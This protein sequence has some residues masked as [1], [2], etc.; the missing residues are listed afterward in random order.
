MILEAQE[1]NLHLT[2]VTVKTAM[3]KLMHQSGYSFVFEASDLI[4]RKKVSVSAD[5]LDS[6]I[7]Q[8]LQGQDVC[9][10]IISKSIVISSCHGPGEK[11]GNKV[12]VDGTVVDMASNPIPGATIIEKGTTN[13]TVCGPDG[14]FAISINEGTDLICSCLG[15]KSII[16]STSHNTA[17][18]VTLCED[19]RHIDESIIVGYGTV[20]RKNVTGSISSVKKEDLNTVSS[21]SVNLMLQGRVSG[22]SSIQQSAQ[23]GAGA[24]IVIRGAASPNGSNSPLYVIDGVP[25]QTFISADPG[26]EIVGYELMT[27]IDRD[28]LNTLNPNDI[29]RIEVLK[30]ASAAIYGASAAN[31][32]I[33]ITTKSGKSGNAKVDYKSVFTSLIKKPYADVMNAR[34][35]REQTNLWTREYYLYNNRMG[36]YGTNPVDYSGYTPVFENLS[37][38]AA[39]TDWMDEVSRK[40]YVIDQNITVNGGNNSTK[41]YFSYNYYDN[42]GL[43]KQ[44]GLKRHV[45]RLNLDHEFSD[46]VQ[47]DIKFNYSAITALSTSVGDHGNG[48]N[49]VMR[50]LDFAPDIPV[51]DAN[52]RYS[53][54]YNILHNNPV[55]FTEIEDKTVSDRIF[56]TPSI[57][58]RILDGLDLKA[59]AGYDAQS[60]VRNFYLPS[61]A[62]NSNVPDGMASLSYGK[63]TNFNGETYLNY[64]NVF[65]SENRL[66]LMAG[67]GYY[68]TSSENFGLSA[69][70]FFTDAFKYLNVSIASD[71]EKEDVRSSKTERTKLS[72]FARVTYSIQDKYLLNGT[73][74]RDGSSYFSKNHKWGVFPSISFAW[75]ISS[76]DFAK[77]LDFIDNLK[78]RAGIGTTGNEN[79]LQGNALALYGT[80]YSSLIGNTMRSGILLTQV[81]NPNLKWE[82]D[83]MLN[84]GMDFALFSSGVN[85]SFEY[86]RKQVSNLL[87][88]QK[89]PSNGAVGRIAANIGETMS[90]GV[91][92]SAG[93]SILDMPGF[94]WKTSLNLSYSVSRWVKRNPEVTIAEY[95]GMKDP[96]DQLYGWET[97]GIIH[98]PDDIPSY[99]PDAKAGNVKYVDQNSDGVLDIYDVVKIGNSTPRWMAG[100]DNKLKYKNWDLD[101]FL[102]YSGGYKKRMG[103]I[104][105]ASKVG[106]HG[107]APSNTYSSII[108][109]VWNSQTKTGYLPGIAT[110]PYNAYNPSGTDDFFLMNSSYLK[111]KYITLSYSVPD[112]IFKHNGFIKS[113]RCFIDA[114]NVWTITSYRG[115]DPELS[116]G[117]PYPQA[118][119]LSLGFNMSF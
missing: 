2:D 24:N 62:M 59:S 11:E 14:K 22:L 71:K 68:L 17:I 97:D 33:L 50:A 89:L 86:Y 108:T 13:G 84:L 44:S 72:Q 119:S 56:I 31:G 45:I 6:A 15:Y 102:Y 53:K 36:L 12:N 70:D 115:F 23:P 69:S 116:T 73:L 109:D 95:I 67:V 9:Y 75:L 81:E 20:S 42:R 63:V 39:D 40:G 114:Q 60:S 35:F 46:V 99:M 64:D 48:D 32:V 105:D 27:G 77:H 25:L 30:D 1:L 103:Q 61:S 98:G 106:N 4:L 26:I 49:M 104:P 111:L 28:P 37:V 18:T 88:Y 79:V 57:N 93:I 107:N 7:M 55:S 66:S 87:D 58:V 10:T 3:N 43:L 113:A 110:N 21:A 82:S 92:L 51:K 90:E 78:F 8:I 19:I 94:I 76:E 65:K 38:F 118:V 91:E 52:G 47:A 29:E 41:Y 83:F 101:F 112:S 96:I 117:N 16:V 80:G 34:Q 5:N 74:R 54:G 85:G 100:L